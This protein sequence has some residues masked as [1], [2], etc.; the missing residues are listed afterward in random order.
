MVRTLLFLHAWNRGREYGKTMEHHPRKILPNTIFLKKRIE[1]EEDL[2][3][4]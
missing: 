3:Y 1:F 4:N 2:R